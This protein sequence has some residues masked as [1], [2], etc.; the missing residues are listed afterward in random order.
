MSAS[1]ENVSN[2]NMED[3]ESSERWDNKTDVGDT[4]EANMFIFHYI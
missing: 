2:H 3:K 4:E 1:E